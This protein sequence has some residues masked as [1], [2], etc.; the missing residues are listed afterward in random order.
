[1]DHGPESAEQSDKKYGKWNTAPK[2]DDG[3]LAEIPEQ[4]T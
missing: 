2:K 4:M 3:I 1:M